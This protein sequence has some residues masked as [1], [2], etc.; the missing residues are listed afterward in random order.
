MSTVR[1]KERRLSLRSREAVL[2]LG[3]LTCS[4]LFLLT[5]NQVGLLGYA[6]APILLLA[7]FVLQADLAWRGHKKAGAAFAIAAAA[8]LTFSVVAAYAFSGFGRAPFFLDTWLK[9][10]LGAGF[11]AALFSLSVLL[12]RKQS[13]NLYWYLGGSLAV[14]TAA[15]AIHPGNSGAIE[16]Q[17]ERG[18]CAA[19]AIAFWPGASRASDGKRPVSVVLPQS[20]SKAR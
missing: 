1:I 4:A 10:L 2:L 17:C 13:V 14:A 18:S 3:T 8:W 15:A 12:A 19:G 9:A 20:D 5:R 16:V 11:F 7:F 6:V